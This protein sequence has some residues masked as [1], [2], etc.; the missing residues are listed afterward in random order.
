MLVTKVGLIICEWQLPEKNGLIFCRELRKNNKHK[1]TPFLLISSENLRKD[2]ILASEG[3]IN[4]YLLKPFS[5]EDFCSQLQKLIV[6]AQS[7]TPIVKLL[8]AGDSHIENGEPWFAGPLYMEALELK[9][10]SK[11]WRSKPHRHLMIYSMERF[12]QLS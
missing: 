8:D 12:H 6:A 11:I 5:Y 7:P 1:A 10:S 3:G 4:A 2:V 9:D